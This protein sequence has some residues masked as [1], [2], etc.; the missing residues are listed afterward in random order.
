MESF[1]Y[2]GLFVLD[3]ANNHQ[4]DVEHGLNIINGCANVVTEMGVRAALKFQYRN[5]ESLIHPDFRDR[6][7][8]PHIP[9]FMETPLPVADLKRLAD[10]AREGGLITMSTPFDEP[11][12]DMLDELGI[13]VLKIASCSAT[14][15][16]LLERAVKSGKPMVVSTAGLSMKRIDQLVSFLES[17][18]AQFALMHCVALYPTQR[19]KLNLNQIEQLRERFPN[20]PVGFSTHEEPDNLDS[21]RIA[22]AKGAQL[23]E[24]HVGLATKKHKL[25]A[26]SSTPDQVRAWIAACKDA[27]AMCGGEERAPASVAEIKSLQSLMRGTY[28]KESI[29]KGAVITKDQV[30]FAMPLQDNQLVSG[31]FREGMVADKDYTALEPLAD[32]LADYSTSREDIIYQILLQ[33]KGMLNEARIP[34]GRDSAVELSHHYGLERFREFGCVLIDCVNRAYCKKLIVMLPRQKH[35]YHYHAKKEETFQLLHGDMEIVMEGH[36]TKLSHGDTFLVM[37]GQWHKFHT[38]DGAIVEEISTTHYN[39]DSFYQDEQIAKIPREQRKTP[40]SNWTWS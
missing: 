17:K 21:V 31:K 8:V 19:D 32:A 1:D 18:R 25:N 14:D 20:V 34:L 2:Q 11:S 24:R 22:Y 28:A 12:V 9:R 16:P 30:F 6:K 36:K 10:A 7:D 38:L 39:N 33:V 40:I 23:F 5:L 27:Q 13:E 3:L 35:P 4:G 15:R 26:Y 37:P 29:G